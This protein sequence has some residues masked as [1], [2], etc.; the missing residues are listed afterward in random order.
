MNLGNYKISVKILSVIF[1]LSVVAIAITATGVLSLGQ[2]NQSTD[3]MQVS[4]QEVLLG[5]RMRQN[6]I[7]LNRAEFRLA[8]DP[9]AGNIADTRKIIDQ[10]VSEIEERIA[11]AMETAGARRK[12]ALEELQGKYKDYKREIDATVSLAESS[13]ASIVVSEAQA[14]L[15]NEVMGSQAASAALEEAAKAYTQVVLDIM[16]EESDKATELYKHASLIMIAGAAIGILAG[17]GLGLVVSRKGI[18]LPIQRIVGS[19]EKLANGK[20]DIDVYGTNRKDEVG[21]IAATTL[22]FKENMIKARN[23]EEENKK[24]QIAKEARQVKVDAATKKFEA[25]MT[26]IVRF[27]AAASTELQSSA[28]ALA[29]AAE[30]T[31]NQSNVVAAAAQQASANVQTVSS[32][33][34]EMSASI[35][36]ISAQIN[37]SSDVANK[38]V[39]DA[40]EAGMSVEVLVQAAQKIG[41]VTQLISGIAEQTNLLALNATIEAARAGDA[42]KGFAV[43]AEEVKNLAN[44]AT[45][46][47]EEISAQIREIQQISQGSAE[48]MQSVC[49]VIEEMG[50]ISGTIAAAIQQQTAATLEISRN[51]AEAYTGTSEVTQNIVSVSDAA[52]GTGS[53]SVEVLS[54]ANE[55][56]KQSTILKTAFD[57]FITTVAA[58]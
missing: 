53:A 34:E 1:L 47:T 9:S 5:A 4:G 23:L 51:V 52:S 18:V 21:N 24:E 25:A 26:E 49:I 29:A 44:E 31:S 20:L 41:D 35:N 43:V 58:A 10:Q 50:Q 39:H 40:R 36:E 15:V 55:L 11:K 2:V 46:A 13:G 45:K 7:A 17:L 19:L 37:K 28:Q 22:V 3:K 30:E 48:S 56:A 12:A 6:A 33:S 14:N 38:A 32:A 42:G 57:D 54:A 8:A 27:V 16:Q